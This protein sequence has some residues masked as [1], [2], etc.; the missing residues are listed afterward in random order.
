MYVAEKNVPQA[1]PQKCICRGD[2]LRES[3]RRC[4]HCIMRLNGRPPSQ[5]PRRTLGGRNACE[6][7]RAAKWPPA[8]YNR[9]Q[10]KE[11]IE[12]IAHLAIAVVQQTGKPIQ[13]TAGAAWRRAVE[14]WLQT[15]GVTTFARTQNCYAVPQ[16]KTLK[17]DGPWRTSRKILA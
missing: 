4:I 11:I 8:A 6:S 14:T 3:E 13:H 1:T 7:F 5:L 10:R 16:E 17:D 2:E 12:E 9:R 15:N